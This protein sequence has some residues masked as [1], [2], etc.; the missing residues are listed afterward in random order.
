MAEMYL[1][2][3]VCGFDLTASNEQYQLYFARLNEAKLNRRRK[4]E[5][6]ERQK[7]IEQ[8]QERQREQALERQQMLERQEPIDYEKG[9]TEVGSS[10][11]DEELSGD[12]NCST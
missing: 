11:E 5:E 12:G 9:E 4:R 8:E 6:K 2:N 3:S 1:S 7:R 10:M